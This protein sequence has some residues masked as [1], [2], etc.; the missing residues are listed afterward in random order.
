MDVEDDEMMA[1]IFKRKHAPIHDKET[2]F[3]VITAFTVSATVTFLLPLSL[4]V[5]GQCTLYKNQYSISAV[6][7]AF[8]YAT[9]YCLIGAIFL[10]SQLYIQLRHIKKGIKFICAVF[11]AICLTVP[12][13]L[14]L[15]SGINDI[16]H[17]IFAVA[18]FTFYSLLTFCIMFDIFTQEVLPQGYEIICCCSLGMLTALILYGVGTMTSVDGTSFYTVYEITA[19]YFVGTSIAVLTA[20]LEVFPIYPM[21]SYFDLEFD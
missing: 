6:I 11:G 2:Y 21:K 7:Q 16:Y 17:E 12:L 18:G 15:D 9:I 10:F 19:E 1:L 8:P 5:T 4:C 3:L 13:M 14:P 20:T